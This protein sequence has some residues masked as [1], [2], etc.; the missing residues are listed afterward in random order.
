MELRKKKSIPASP[1][2]ADNAGR[3]CGWAACS[4]GI[5]SLPFLT[6]GCHKNHLGHF[7]RKVAK[8]LRKSLSEKEKSRSKMNFFPSNRL[9]SDVHNVRRL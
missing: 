2:S 1:G 7:L 6:S 5:L 3:P 9:H 8:T 4:G